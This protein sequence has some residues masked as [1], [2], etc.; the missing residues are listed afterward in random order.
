MSLVPLQDE[1]HGVVMSMHCSETHDEHLFPENLE[2][3]QSLKDRY[4]DYNYSTLMNTTFGLVPAGRSPGTY[5]LG[6]VMSAGAIP[7]FVG[8][9]IVPPFREQFDW[10]SFSF[11]FSPDEVGP[12]LLRTLWAIPRAQLRE[13]QVGNDECCHHAVVRS[14]YFSRTRVTLST[15]AGGIGRLGKS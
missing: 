3:C 5:R 2:Y 1:D 10:P 15:A 13:M 6:E 9:E 7:V 12:F 4:G 11:C 14:K 8:R